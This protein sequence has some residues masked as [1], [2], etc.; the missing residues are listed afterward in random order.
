MRSFSLQF[1]FFFRTAVSRKLFDIRFPYKHCNFSRGCLLLKTV[2]RPILRETSETKP[3]CVLFH[4]SMR[5][6]PVCSRAQ[7]SRQLWSLERLCHFLLESVLYP[8]SLLRYVIPLISRK[9]WG[10]TDVKQT[11]PCV[12]NSEHCFWGAVSQRKLEWLPLTNSKSIFL[13]L[14]NWVPKITYLCSKL[15]LIKHINMIQ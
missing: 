7:G 9:E 12:Q 3:V 13:V 15:S 11:L 4:S 14:L 2:I 1:I 5:N 10:L 8:T 6:F